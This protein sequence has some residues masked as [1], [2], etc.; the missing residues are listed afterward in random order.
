VQP[1]RLALFLYL[2]LAN[3]P[4]LH[5]R[6]SLLALFWP[7]SRD[8]QARLALRQALHF[9][10]Q[11]LGA[12]ALTSRGDEEIGVDFS[13]VWCDVREFER[14]LDAGRVDEALGLYRG[15]LLEG[16]HVSGVAIE[17]EHWL[18]E[19][20]RRLRGR[21]VAALR[22]RVEHAARDGNDAL[23]IERLRDLLRLEPVSEPA[24]RRLM[25]LLDREG[26]RSAALRAY[27]EMVR[28][29][30]SDL[31][32]EPAPDTVA[33]AERLRSAR[34]P[35]SS[36]P[37]TIAPPDEPTAA[38]AAASAG[39]SPRPERRH[40]LRRV[41][42]GAAGLLAV[43]AI[44]WGVTRGRGSSRPAASV[45]L[46]VGLVADHTGDSSGSA[47]LMRDLLATDLARVPGITV[48]SHTRI[49]EL[50]ARFA[51]TEE[52]QAALTRAARAAGA[53]EVL[54]GDLG[55]AAN[56]MLRLTLRRV[57]VGSGVIRHAYDAEGDDLF[58]LV[59]R[60]SEAVAEERGMRP[61]APALS[62][63]T[64]TSLV[65]RR[66][67]DEGV[68]AYY[69]GDR[70]SALR[71]FRAAL[72]EDS[73]FAMAAYFAARTAWADAPV[74]LEL[75][76]RA[77]RM[78]SRATERER[79]LI[80]AQWAEASNSPS[81]VTW[82]ES[83]ALRFPLEPEAQFA[84]GRTLVWSG[85]FPRAIGHLRR[86]IERDSLSAPMDSVPGAADRVPCTACDAL[87]V[88][89][90]AYQM[91]DSQAAAERTSREW[92]RRQPRSATAWA[93][94]AV[95]LELLGR[96]AEA[97]DA[98]RTRQA[99][100][101]DGIIDDSFERARMALREGDFAET[102][103]ILAER[104]RSGGSDIRSEVLWWRVIS[105]R[106]RGRLRDA[107]T[108]ARRFRAT[109]PPSVR[110]LGAL[111]EGQVLYELG[112]PAEAARLF[113]STA[114]TRRHVTFSGA[115]DSTPGLYA[116]DV[117]WSLMHAATSYAAAG[118]TARVAKLA[119]ALE[120]LAP[121]DAYWRDRA[122]PFHARGLLLLARGDLDGAEQA[123]RRAI[124][125]PTQGYTRSN[126]ELG[127]LLVRQ[128][129]PREAA[130][131]LA[132][133]LRGDVQASNYYATLTELHEAL[134]Q[135]LDAAGEH[136]SA[137]VHYRWVVRAWESADPPFRARAARARA[138]V[139]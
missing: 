36:A 43:A 112:R 129:R 135:A 52:T 37:A 80:A 83:L 98:W 113:E 134:A 95:A 67:Y 94:H 70:Q 66:F 8:E 108:F 1:K 100:G 115:P 63:L 54:E 125:S 93:N 38:A 17:L 81:L 21:A 16:F 59:D 71:L 74:A 132:P 131:V 99:L 68:R 34:P 110:A 119:D 128:G 12:D 40:R 64:T 25:T 56:G 27:E 42:V 101:T 109:S 90:L 23:A 48:V 84:L 55:R 19:E 92:L 31:D 58:A 102:E 41:L 76:A 97:S 44:V 122:L 3:P 7:E 85:D 139:E 79:L 121:V 91:S 33:L 51:V 11:T 61:P 57:D 10:R 5:R 4:R 126:L 137:R 26:D 60:V 14:A 73:T 120:R 47:T 117:M 46:A 29:L 2:A 116:R 104:E 87:S 106:N 32:V 118:D 18:D 20:R 103:R 65:A 39:A 127:R 111:V 30:R 89:V 82:A 75:S 123:F 72:V 22:T 45:V 49:Q 133:A 78:S 53:S 24:L 96:M 62:S 35:A 86:A 77:V 107:L 15:H 130:A 13:V 50:L 69:Q 114:V 138:A 28:R 88:L 124:V 6:D 9:L 105:A 136:D